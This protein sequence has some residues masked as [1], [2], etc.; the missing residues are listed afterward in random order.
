MLMA[1][2]F[3]GGIMN[4]VWIAALAILVLV[5][6]A[7]PAGPWVGR[8]AGIALIAWGSATLLV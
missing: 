4:L 5:E 6:K 1:L 7:F 2:L 8:A 3:V